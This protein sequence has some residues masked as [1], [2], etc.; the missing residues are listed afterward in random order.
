MGRVDGSSLGPD[1][2][3]RHSAVGEHMSPLSVQFWLIQHVD[4]ALATLVIEI[5]VIGCSAQRTR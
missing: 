3:S 4:L 1:T 5:S 2:P